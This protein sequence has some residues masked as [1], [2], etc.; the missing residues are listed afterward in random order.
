M[1][2]TW[3][4][5]IQQLLDLKVG[6]ESVFVVVFHMPMKHNLVSLYRFIQFTPLCPNG[7]WPKSGVFVNIQSCV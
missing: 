2:Q 7:D 3:A 4:N 5:D 6:S 1:Y